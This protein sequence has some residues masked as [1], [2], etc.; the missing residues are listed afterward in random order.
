MTRLLREYAGTAAV[1]AAIVLRTILSGMTLA[2]ETSD[3]RPIAE[4]R[5]LP[6]EE[7]AANRDVR[8]R[9]VVTR[10]SSG[11]LFLQDET[12][13]IYVN[14]WMAQSRGL[15][16]EGDL[17]QAVEPGIEVEIAGTVDPGGFSPPILPRSITVL[18]SKPLPTPQPIDPEQFF[19]GA[20]DS[21]L[22]EV[23][24][25]VQD[26][27]DL[28]QTGWRL[29][30]KA[31]SRTF[32]AEVPKSVLTGDPSRL[33][34][35]VIRVAGPVASVFNTRG[36]FLMPR[37]YVERPEWL[38]VVKPSLHPPFESPKVPISA[39]ARFR[40]QLLGDHMI[41][42]EGVVVYAV[43]GALV[44]LQSGAGGVR[45]K[46]RFSERLEPGDRV[47]VAGFVDRSSG[48]AGLA[49]ALVRR[50]GAGPI[51]E[52][53]AITPDEILKVNA[54]ATRSSL[55]A[56]PGDYEGCLVRFPATLVEPQATADGGVL[57]LAAG[58]TNVTASV[59][60]DSF[61][62]LRRL[63]PGSELMVTGIARTDW[64]FDPR[65]WPAQLPARMTLLVRSPA[66]VA[67]LRAPSWWTPRRLAT[68]LAGSAAV[69]AGAL[70]WVWL[71][72]R[73]LLLQK[74]LVA[75]E[76][77]T[78]RDA[79]VEFDA[80]LRERNRLAANLH[81]TLLQTLG[82]IGYQLDA[83]EG[84]RGRDEE[85][86]KVHFDVARRMVG[87]ATSELHHSVWAMRSLPISGQTF[88]DAIRT[89]VGRVA[90]G[91]SARVD[92][93]VSGAFA[94]IPD[95]VAGNLLLIAQEAVYNALRHG[96]PAMIDV[97]MREDAV[98]Q[99]IRLHVHDD[100]RGFAF[101][102]Q[103][104]IEQGHFGLQGMRERT[105]RL[106]GSLRIES[107]LAGG[108]SVFAE[109]RRREYDGTLDPHREGVGGALPVVRG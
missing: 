78:R 37:L 47:E 105:E 91:Y 72:R 101:G 24:A 81:D 98:T 56:S 53:I 107:T 49:D 67:L 108:T 74:K 23:C 35:A 80:T 75:N 96:R 33:I 57:V 87:H 1:S 71:L 89:L 69:L 60:A 104:G 15:W 27:A 32:L 20:A 21:Q 17:P 65:A 2:D 61:V 29:T 19:N 22:V 3:V 92:V 97:Q 28:G 6:L 88:P 31:F 43:P 68:L 45:V 42:V 55:M 18:G 11:S 44:H 48:V 85:D 82:G 73:E 50:L 10:K 25:V 77:R 13:G 40:P 62:E 14:I 93:Q 94:D 84:S 51:P 100:G 36:E 4:I 83:C 7:L 30:L 63:Q 41:R 52:P 102:T 26:V 70:A 86:S 79:A 9:G 106:G 90:E 103:P 54:V 34:N 5:A 76:V 109:V 58:K 99:S 46:S 16:T 38:A 64:E 39:I 12:A 66:D 8:I 59:P 95:F